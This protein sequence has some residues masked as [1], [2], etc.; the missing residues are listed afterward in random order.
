MLVS[1]FFIA[2]LASLVGLITG[3]GGGVIIKPVL[4][5]IHF[6]SIGDINFFSSAAV[7]SMSCLSI[8]KKRNQL[9]SIQLGYVALICVGSIIGGYLGSSILSMLMAQIDSKW[10]L[11]IQSAILIILLSVTFY[12]SN[13]DIKYNI[14][15]NPVLIF[16][17]GIVLG[18][19][20]SFLGIGGGPFNI[21][22]FKNILGFSFR[23]S[24]LYSIII[25]LFSQGTNMV[26]LLSSFGLHAFDLQFAVNIVLSSLLGTIMGI[27]LEPKM[28]EGFLN[29]I[30]S[31]V[32]IGLIIL[33]GVNLF[34]L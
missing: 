12:I 32:L 24:A 22:V 33:N 3:I 14:K 31:F 25:I 9:K 34:G 27:Y 13:N 30:L 17:F 29:R 1:Y 10:I 23:E 6:H 7:I 28:D 21:L 5:L 20:S 19:T 16:A 8:V 11:K 15:S 4:D 2:L 26:N 18:S